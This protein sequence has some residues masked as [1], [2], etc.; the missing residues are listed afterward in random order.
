MHDFKKLI[1]YNEANELALGLYS[2][3]EKFPKNE[4]YRIVD[5]I[6]RAA[7]SIGANIAEGAGRN[8][9]KDFSKFLF[10]SLG[11][12]NEVEHF[13]F[14]SKELGYISGEQHEKYFAKIRSLAGKIRSLIDH[15]SAIY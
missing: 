2:L 12:L 10:N 8:T 11:S 6:R 1:V 15:F 14:L 7:T 13:L 9:D 4:L 5:Q 3:T